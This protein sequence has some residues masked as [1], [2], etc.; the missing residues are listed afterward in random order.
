MP[1]FPYVETRRP[2]EPGPAGLAWLAALA[3]LCLAACS[4]SGSAPS[5]DNGG[6]GGSAGSGGGP[7]T[8]TLSVRAVSEQDGQ[9]V[10]ATKLDPK[11]SVTLIATARPSAARTLRFALLGDALDASL[12]ATDVD[13]ESLSGTAQVGLTAPSAPATFSVRV[14]TPGADPVE[15]PVAVPTTGVATL[16]LSASYAG[17]RV[18]PP[19]YTATAWE[20]KTCADLQGTPPDDGEVSTMSPTYPVTLEVKAGIPL[21]VILRAGRFI[22]GCA[23][24][25][26]LTEGSFREIYVQLTDVPIKLDQSHVHFTL[27]LSP[28][29]PFTDALG[30][31]TDAILAAL[32]GTATDDVTA[33][34]DAMQGTLADDA[35]FRSTRRAEKWDST[36]RDALPDGAQALRSTLGGWIASGVAAMPFDA[37]LVGDL[38][39]NSG[40]PPTLSLTSAFG[41]AAA[42][43]TFV[44]AGKTSWS[45][46]ADDSVLIGLGV[47]FDPA[48]LLLGSALG[49]AALAAPD[50]VDLG[51]ALGDIWCKTVAQTLVAHGESAKHSTDDCNEACTEALCLAGIEVLVQGASTPSAQPA[52][53]DIALT[54]TGGVG[55]DANLTSLG[56]D[57]LGSLVMPS[58][59]PEAP[60]ADPIGPITLLGDATALDPG[61]ASPSK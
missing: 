42:T 35:A 45:A 49:P 20:N 53:L 18:V 12:D 44:P 30:P 23:T 33:L 31:P 58:A 8:V 28:A 1:Y 37:A 5:G 25:D 36:V 56:G 22:W 32:V 16:N 27:S 38:T 60:D 3:A 21:A 54:G 11:G 24:V 26:A 4:G 34:L 43:S 51:A 40:S 61:A 13:T 10:D 41:L 2:R 57:W 29:T 6:T 39:G 52:T 15:L 59:T 46:Q 50:A 14:T 7:T 47:S 48:G 17:E 19:D 9:T 55:V